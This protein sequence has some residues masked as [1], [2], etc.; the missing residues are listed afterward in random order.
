MKQEIELNFDG[1][2]ADN[3][4]R[5]LADFLAKELPDWPARV[6]PGKVAPSAPGTRGG[7]TTLA[8]IALVLALPGTIKNT[9][10]LA[11]RM[12]L[13]TQLERLIAWAKERRARGA[14]NPVI[15]LPPHGAPVPLDQA[16]PEQLLGA[17]DA[18]A[19][20]APPRS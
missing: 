16:K 5:E 3:D 1:Q 20:K 12:K 18:Q 2:G 6:G 9:I 7:A 19:T 11:E 15:T 4:A 10:D 13:K 8:I 17:L 14:R